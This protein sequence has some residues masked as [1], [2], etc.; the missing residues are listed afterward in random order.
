MRS[1]AQFMIF[2]GLFLFSLAA[3]SQIGSLTRHGIGELVL[4]SRVR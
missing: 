3:Y 1:F 4:C 2:G